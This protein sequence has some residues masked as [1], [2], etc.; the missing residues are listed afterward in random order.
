MTNLAWHVSLG[1]DS[2]LGVSL[3]F[4]KEVQ[5]AG[6]V[7]EHHVGCE[8][9][10]FLASSVCLLRKGC[11]ALG[12]AQGGG[13]QEETTVIL[14]V[15]HTWGGGYTCLGRDIRGDENTQRGKGYYRYG[16]FANPGKLPERGLSPLAL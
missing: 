7:I 4:D 11:H 10:I 15:V 2:C 8:G 3:C 6:D 12:I 14:R 13:D 1:H 16:V 9:D 5:A